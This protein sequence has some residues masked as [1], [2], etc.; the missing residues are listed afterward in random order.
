MVPGA[1][2]IMFPNYAYK[3]VLCNTVKYRGTVQR[4][5]G[6]T[7]MKLKENLQ[8]SKNYINSYKIMLIDIKLF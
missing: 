2:P 1:N 3:R 5:Q 7:R 6:I 4:W 8:T